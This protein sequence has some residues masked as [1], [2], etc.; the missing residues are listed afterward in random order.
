MAAKSDSKGGKRFSV[1]KWYRDKAG[2]T[3][4]E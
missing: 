2:Q 4:Q 1:I 3:G